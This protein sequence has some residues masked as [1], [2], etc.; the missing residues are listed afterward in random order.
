LWGEP[1]MALYEPGGGGAISTGM[2]GT[3]T[4]GI[5]LT[6]SATQVNELP[7][8]ARYLECDKEAMS[9]CKTNRFNATC[10]I[11]RNDIVP[12]TA[13]ARIPDGQA[14]WHPGNRV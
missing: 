8:A 6:T 10:W 9:L 11:E 4:K 5:P 1:D 7:Y 12:P 2:W 3:S 13:Q 14:S